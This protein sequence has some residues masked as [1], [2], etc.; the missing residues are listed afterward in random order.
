MPDEFYKELKVFGE[1]FTGI[2]GRSDE[3]AA[4]AFFFEAGK[5]AELV[6]GDE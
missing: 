4:D 6:E 3:V 1:E 5:V 2:Y